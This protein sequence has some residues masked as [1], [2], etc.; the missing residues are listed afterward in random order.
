MCLSNV[1]LKEKKE[2]RLFIKEASQLLADEQEVRLHTIIGDSKRLES[3]FIK[4][5]NLVDNYVILERK[6]SEADA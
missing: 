3:Y 1:Y 2:N 5:V 4:E 6:K